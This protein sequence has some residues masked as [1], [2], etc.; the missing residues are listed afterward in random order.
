MHLYNI[1]YSLQQ[2]FAFRHTS[3]KESVRSE[4]VDL[5]T[6]STHLTPHINGGYY[7]VCL[8]FPWIAGLEALLLVRSTGLHQMDWIINLSLPWMSF[9]Y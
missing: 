7:Q 6:E 2:A 4:D 1:M 8:C 3:D 5:L 9:A